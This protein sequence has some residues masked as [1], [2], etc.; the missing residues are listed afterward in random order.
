[1]SIL[2]DGSSEH[3]DDGHANSSEQPGTLG[4]TDREGASVLEALA[5]V[6]E[7]LGGGGTV[8]EGVIEGER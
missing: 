1:M 8:D 7:E 4:V 6:T 5:D 2:L 3:C